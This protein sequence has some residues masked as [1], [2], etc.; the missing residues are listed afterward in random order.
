[1]GT[2]QMCGFLGSFAD[3]NHRQDS[4]L[5]VAVKCVFKCSQACNKMSD[6]KV[7][8]AKYLYARR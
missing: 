2:N 7:S 3:Q 1:M 5:V 4:H 6:V 8:A